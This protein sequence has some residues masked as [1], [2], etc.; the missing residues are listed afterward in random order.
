MIALSPSRVAAAGRTAVAAATLWL[1]GCADALFAPPAQAP[2]SVVV[3]YSL[4]GGA[5][6]SGPQA[7]FDR[8]NRVRIRLDRDGTRIVDQVVETSRS[9]ADIRISL[10]VALNGEAETLSLALQLQQDDRP[11]FGGSTTVDLRRGET[12]RAEVRVTPIAAGVR[13]LKTLPTL[14]SIGDTLQLSGAVVFA[15]GDTIT[16]VPLTWST[17]D[18][19]VAQVNAQGVLVSRA[20]G[21]ARVVGA[22]QGFADTATVRVAAR[23][24]SI[25]VTPAQPRI[26]V[27]GTTQMSAVLR[28]ARGNALTGRTVTWASS[29]TRIATVDAAGMVRGAAAGQVTITGS[30]DGRSGSAAV[31][32][33]T[34]IQLG[35]VVVD[36]ASSSIRIW[37]NGAED[38]DRVRITLNGTVLHSDLTLTN[39]GTVIPVRYQEGDNVVAILALNQGTSGG[40]TA[41]VGFANVVRGVATKD[42]SLST[43]ATAEVRVIYEPAQA[44]APS[45]AAH[46]PPAPAYQVCGAGPGAG[47]ECASADRPPR[48]P[49]N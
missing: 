34:A 38:G 13:V 14:Q 26:Q 17:P 31:T 30:S 47:S 16:G 21:Q 3:S 7:A 9:G 33:T 10:P 20:E 35:D 44:P 19:S 49:A 12:T 27:G 36:Q 4:S 45:A 46:A 28:D 8:A 23:V 42:Y 40:N 39:A 2:A 37:D 41:S 18:V 11:L 24:A 6:S 1:G 22:Y 48:G 32:V 43:G 29:D 25:T 15:S 5:G